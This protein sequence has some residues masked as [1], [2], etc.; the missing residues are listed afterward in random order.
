MLKRKKLK[1]LRKYICK[2]IPEESLFKDGDGA[3]AVSLS[4][5]TE[6]SNSSQLEVVDPDSSSSVDSVGL[7]SSP[8]CFYKKYK[9]KFY[10][11]VYQ[12]F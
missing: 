2:I 7:R 12:R 5:G 11:N 9:H 4:S 10:Q 3:L 6:R 1:F 8:K